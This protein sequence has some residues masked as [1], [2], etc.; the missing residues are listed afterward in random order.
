MLSLNYY[1][2]K[3]HENVIFREG[4]ILIPM[5]LCSMVEKLHMALICY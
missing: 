3:S 2:L 4:Y 5:E 1:T